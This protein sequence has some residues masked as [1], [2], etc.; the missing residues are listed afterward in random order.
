MQTVIEG[1]VRGI[2]SL[3]GW[4][5]GNRMLA[6]HVGAALQ[7]CKWAGVVFAGGMSEIPHIDARTIVVNDL[8]RHII[9]LAR[10]V[11]DDKLRP[12]LIRRLDRYAFHPDEL[13][14]CQRICKGTDAGEAP[15]LELAEAYFVCCWMNRGGTAGSS[16]E[17]AGRPSIRW[18]SDGGDS[19]VRYQSAVRMLATFSRALRRCTFETMDCFDFLSRCEDIERHGI[20]C[21]PPFPGP[22]R[23]YLHNAG[24]TE[25][26]ETEW[27]RQLQRALSRFEN[28]TLVCRF[29]EHP[30]VRQLY[31]DCDG[32]QCR[33]LEGRKQTNDYADELLL[34]N[35]PLV[36]ASLFE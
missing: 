20:Y 7:G 36:A 19:R 10:V 21:D 6:K 28:A 27:H 35:R 24:A 1:D 8:H 16:N 22:G 34:I 3:A 14:E 5:G 2:S 23:R 17:F 9:N 33:K 32:W 4:Y 13:A 18:K 26:E 15:S 11:R 25:Q 29:Y 30:L 31:R 12:V